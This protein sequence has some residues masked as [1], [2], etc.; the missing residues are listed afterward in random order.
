MSDNAPQSGK[1]PYALGQASVIRIPVPGTNGL[2]LELR[3]RGKVPAGGS[4]STVFVQDSVGKRHL[5]LDYGY[6]KT[7]QSID[8]H[9]NQKGT[10]SN[11][12]ITDHKPAG[13]TGAVA[14]RAA[15][16]FR[17]AGRTLLVT[18]VLVDVIAVVQANNRLRRASEAVTGWAAG[19]IGCKAVGAVGAGLGTATA[20]GLGTAAG[21]FVGCV[22]GGIGGYA[23]GSSLAGQV[24]DWAEG[25]LFAPLQ[26][27]G[28]P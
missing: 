26:E 3:P 7:T 24:Y 16:Y 18:G 17:Y 6:N 23:A 28:Q 25:T 9:W 19:W 10:H 11:F 20:P 1:V 5:R 12:G 14:Y 21:G 8:F 27:V 2:C 4:T 15:K 22:V 13:R